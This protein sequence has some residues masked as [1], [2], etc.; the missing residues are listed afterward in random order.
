[1]TGGGGPRHW[2]GTLG[3]SWSNYPSKIA[4]SGRYSSR[5]A[6]LEPAARFTMPPVSFRTIINIG[7]ALP[8]ACFAVAVPFAYAAH[9]PPLAMLAGVAGVC[10]TLGIG[11]GWALRRL[12]LRVM[13]RVLSEQKGENLRFDTAINN[14][15]QGLCFFDGD[16]RL[17]VCNRR[18]AEMY[19]LSLDILRPGTTLRE[20]VDLRF[21]VGSC[22]AMSREDYLAWRNSI[23]ISDRPSDTATELANGRIFAIHHQPMPGG[24]W[25]A[26][27]DDITDRRRTEAQIERMAR[28]DVLTGLANRVQF[29]ERLNDLLLQSRATDPVAILLVDLDRFKAVND[30]LGHPIGDKLLCAAAQRLRQFVRQNDL[31]ARLGGDEFAL[32]QPGAS[33]PAA[34]KSLA[35][36]LVH[37]FAEP[38]EIGDDQVQVGASVGVA[39][40]PDDG[41]DP[42]ELLK[43]ADLALYDAKST[44]RGTLSFFRSEMNERAQG[45]RALEIDLRQAEARGEL[46]LHYQP[47]LALNTNRVTCFEALLRWRHPVRGMV[48]PDSFIPLAEETGLI[49]S[50]GVWV[51]REAFAQATTW[52]SHV[53]I[54]VN[55]SPVQFKSGKLLGVVTAALTGSGIEP[56]RVEPE[57]TESVRL[58]EDAANLVTLHA[59]RSLGVRIC[60]DDFGVGY[61]SLSYLRSFPFKKIKI[62]RSFIRDVVDNTEA[63]A[64][65]RAITTLGASL[66]ML[67]TAEGVEL[68]EQV[69][70]LRSLGCDEAQGYLFSRP[71]PA[72]ELDT[73]L[74]ADRGL[75]GPSA[76]ALAL[77][78][79]QF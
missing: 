68:P 77:V 33:Q 50:L 52:P 51:L 48:M 12:A 2:A 71:L 25:V 31:V 78:V 22:P 21:E 5:P 14:M 7:C 30:T 10:A 45:R 43:R 3:N 46:E 53:G 16:E 34:A 64:I 54:A 19:G 60:L 59:L 73:M 26:T 76:A 72:S 58:T 13:D 42:D 75:V 39:L 56:Q 23:A 1:M 44:G 9:Q 38:F 47:I 66:G 63:A 15:S 20:I 79:E 37:G 29:R 18:Y 70:V 61:S 35:D 57:I 40:S 32:I 28:S 6:Q 8:S 69:Q 55:L 49:E 17:I 36:R 67:T 27:H 41:V 24:G 11:V 4:S 62:D 74:Q 65:V